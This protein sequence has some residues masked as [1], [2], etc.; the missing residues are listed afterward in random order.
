MRRFL[1]VPLAFAV[2]MA[3]NNE[4]K[5]DE[6]KTDETA[7]ITKDPNYQKGN[8]MVWSSSNDCRTCHNIND[9]ISGPAF[10]E[11]ASKYAGMPDTIVTHLAKKIIDG[12]SGVWGEVVMPAHPNISQPDA[13]TMVKYILLLKK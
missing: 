4:S 7:D 6:K 5:P 2:L 13:E 12:G 3:C 8:E 11:V 10:K 9:R 1:I